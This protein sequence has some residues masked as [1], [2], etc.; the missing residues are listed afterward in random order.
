MQ[1]V[2]TGS[3]LFAD[4]FVGGKG[5]PIL[6]ERRIKHSTTVQLSYHGGLAAWDK[7]W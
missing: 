7:D 2:E 3:H 6:G 5:F 1:D 4:L